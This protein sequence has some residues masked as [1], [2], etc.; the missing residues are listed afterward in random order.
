MARKYSRRQRVAIQAHSEKANPAYASFITF[1]NL[2]QP[3]S[4][5]RAYK[6][7]AEEGYGAND[8]V[9]KCIQYIITNGAAI[10]PK[11]YSDEAHEHEIK[12]HP[13]LD[14]L[15]K[16]NVEQTCVDLFE[17]ILGYF[18]ISG[19]AYMLA[20]RPNP[21]KPP[22]ELWALQPDKIK[23]VVDKT[24][25]I[26][27]YN[28]DDYSDD[29]NPIPAA[30]IGRM[31]TWNPT[32]PIYG[33]SPIEVGAIMIDQQTA[34]MKWN[35]ALM[36]NF[37]KMS[38]AWVAPVSLGKNERDALEAKVNDKFAGP[39]NAGRMPVLDA[40]MK[41][42]QMAITP[43]DTD[44]KTT[45]STNAIALANLFNIAPQLIGD[46]A[47]STYDNYNQAKAAS[48]TEA[49]F[50]ILDRFYAMLTNWLLPMFGLEAFLYYDKTTIEVLQEVIQAQK[51]AEAERAVNAYNAGACTLNQALEAQ[52][53][54]NIGP[55][56]DVYKL[57]NV[58]VPAAKL[59]DYA[60]QSLAEP[61][62]PPIPQAE[63]LPPGDPNSNPANDSPDKPPA[64]AKPDDAPA[65]APPANKAADSTNDEDDDD[66]FTEEP[67][68]RQRQREARRNEYRMFKEMAGL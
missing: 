3:H 6:N 23:A 38:G 16:P 35:L 32:D 26:V 1:N 19:N 61:A 25:G 5:P 2:P 34:A 59:Q 44:W 22:A 20:I 10:P 56:G 29:Q 63:P 41:W 58:L 64:P 50:P 15:K 46:T 37:G 54:E 14:L 18:L 65:P 9:Y 47:S 28:F 36:Q 21:N 27:G 4:M 55:S 40:G 42:Q 30:N 17:A 11:L 33:K 53:F 66:L 39:R 51:N 31:K 57:G 67:T 24:R 62:A 12:D 52:G 13:V 43:V 45:R 60:E 48:Y 68:Y 8:T 49:I 7:F